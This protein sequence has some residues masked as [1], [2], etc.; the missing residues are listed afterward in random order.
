[1]VGWGDIDEDLSMLELI[2]AASFGAGVVSGAVALRTWQRRK[3]T[4]LA[5]PTMNLLAARYEMLRSA[6]RRP[7]AVMLGDSLTAGVPWSEIADCP[8]VA[9]Y[10]WNG[11]TSAGVVY[12]LK[13]IIL[14]RPRA[15]FLMVGAN[16][17]LKGVSASEIAANIR[18]IVDG[19][20]AEGIAVIW[21][22]ILPFVGAD[23]IDGLN[24]VIAKALKG[25]NVKIVPLPI[26]I[27]DLRDGLHLGPNGARKW[28]DTIR[29]LLREHCSHYHAPVAAI[30]A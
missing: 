22:P 23:H 19:L 5:A 24:R 3:L 4:T 13:E 27:D 16:D 15:V 26:D 6:T 17:V 1:V 7:C 2:A 28:H 9:N 8:S 18:T 30:S 12:R 14:L 29:P 25:T 20:E 10:G 21:H 11:D